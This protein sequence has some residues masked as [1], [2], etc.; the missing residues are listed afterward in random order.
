MGASYSDVIMEGGDLSLMKL[1]PTSIA[2]GLR[3]VVLSEF[4]VSGMALLDKHQ[5]L[6]ILP[7]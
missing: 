5:N 7:D 3:F 1:S 6:A 4:S 2:C